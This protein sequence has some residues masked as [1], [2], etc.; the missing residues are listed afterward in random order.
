[1]GQPVDSGFSCTES[2]GGPGISSCTD[3]NGHASGAA[4][5]TSTTGSHTLTVTA[6]S[7]DGQAGTASTSYT[8]TAPTATALASTTN[9]SAIGQQ[10]TYTA[11]VSPMPDGGSIAFSDGASMI[12]DC[13]TVAVQTLTG[14][15]TCRVAYQSS[16]SHAIRATYSGDADFTGSQSTV[17]DQLV[18][19]ATGANRLSLSG[20]PS[21]NGNGVSDKL[22]CAA[23]P[24][25]PCEVTETL[26]SIE[27]TQGGQ[28]IAVSATHA[29]HK[30]RTVVLATKTVTIKPGQRVTMTVSLNG[31]GRKLLKRFRKLPVKLTVAL[32]VSGKHVTVA[33]RTLKLRPASERHHRQ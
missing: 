7:G 11:T 19:T 25:R 31:T 9:P 14:Q 18:A 26:T 30:Q 2:T 12:S 21:S 13:A 15:A 8:V 10:V 4:I 32:T 29:K 16:E 20:S 5:D 1:V 6:T 23:S 33:T 28:P 22:S 3:Q 24:P 17:L 27:T